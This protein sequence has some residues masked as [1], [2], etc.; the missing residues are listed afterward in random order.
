VL[1]ALAGALAAIG[2]ARRASRI[3]VLDAL[4]HQ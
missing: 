1:G 4:T 2:P 3:D